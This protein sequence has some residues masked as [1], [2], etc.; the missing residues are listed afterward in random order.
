MTQLEMTLLGATAAA[1]IETAVLVDE[2]FTLRSFEFSLDPG[3][4]P[5]SVHGRLEGPFE[6]PGTDDPWRLILEI[7]TG[8]KTRTETRA[9]SEPPLL[10]ATWAADSRVKGL[11][12]ALVTS[13]CCSTRPRSATLPW[14]SM[15]VSVRSSG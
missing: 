15:L 6:E 13:G 8:G 1:R 3:T 2:Q 12:R 10:A 9:L 4:G 11:L 14:C 7:T 5:V